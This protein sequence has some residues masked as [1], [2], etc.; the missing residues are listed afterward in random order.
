V[1][2]TKRC[3]HPEP[4]TLVFK[5]LRGRLRICLNIGQNTIFYQENWSKITK[6][7]LTDDSRMLMLML[8]LPMH[9]ELQEQE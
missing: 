2:P 3:L 6:V 1:A 5:E 8:L 7:A 4:V 9:P